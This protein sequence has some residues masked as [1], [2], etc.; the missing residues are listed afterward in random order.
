MLCF[1][2]AAAIVSAINTAIHSIT[3]SLDSNLELLGLLVS[4]LFY[5]Y[6]V[7]FHEWLLDPENF[8]LLLMLKEGSYARL[9]F[10]VNNMHNVTSFDVVFCSIA[11]YITRILIDFAS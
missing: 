8:T 1:K 6:L 10:Y 7:K 3:A 9:I 11:L 4:F 5:M 2:I